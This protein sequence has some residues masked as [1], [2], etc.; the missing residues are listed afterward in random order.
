MNQNAQR[1]T[2][3]RFFWDNTITGIHLWAASE[4]D[5]AALQRMHNQMQE[6]IPQSTS[7]MPEGLM[8]ML[9]YHLVIIV[10]M[11][12][13]DYYVHCKKNMVWLIW[14]TSLSFSWLHSVHLCRTLIA[15]CRTGPEATKGRAGAGSGSQSISS[16]P[17]Y[18]VIYPLPT[19]FKRS[20][21]L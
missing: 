19:Y 7:A 15:A 13:S 14:R 2:T 17:S 9:Y 3:A 11:L 10:K 4:G 6:L 21:K 8:E 1:L 5:R 18:T 20:F 16:K 12:N